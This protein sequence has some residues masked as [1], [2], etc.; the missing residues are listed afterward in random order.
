MPQ[1]RLVPLNSFEQFAA[2]NLL[3]D[4][5][6]IGGPVVIPNCVQ[7]S[8]LWLQEDGR[9]A[10]N[11]LFGRSPGVPAPTVAQANGIQTAL[12]TGAAWTALAA[13][14]ATSTN[15]VQ[16]QIKSVH[17]ASQ[18]AV[19][20]TNT[21]SPGTSASPAYPNEVSACITKRTALTGQAN[22][23]RM[24]IPGFATNAGAAGNVISAACVT[25]LTNWGNTIGTA[26]SGQGYTHVIGQQARAAYT[27]TTGTPHA[28][29]PAGSVDVTQMV[30]RDNHW[31]TQRRRGLR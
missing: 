13:F 28:A 4:P 30:M 14:L 16:V 18:T 29:R 19:I 7:I 1:M 17:T 10:F 2:I 12:G 6:A 25:A 26:L 21:G 3:L 20:S 22:R 11:V 24:Y 15:L 27:G 31:D 5:G 9:T 23:G 8:L